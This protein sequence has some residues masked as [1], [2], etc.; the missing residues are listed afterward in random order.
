[1]EDHPSGRCL[2]APRADRSPPL[3]VR[4]SG[5]LDRSQGPTQQQLQSVG[6]TIAITI[7]IVLSIDHRQ[8]TFSAT[9]FQGAS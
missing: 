8:C 4:K 2:I 7:D 1:V 9:V 3:R 5:V 6:E